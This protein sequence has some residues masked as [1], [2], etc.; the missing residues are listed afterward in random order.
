MKG[1]AK[2]TKTSTRVKSVKKPSARAAL[3]AELGT[4]TYEL[5]STGVLPIPYRLKSIVESIAKLDG[6]E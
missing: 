2:S 4:E 5:L 6:K 3:I 1:K